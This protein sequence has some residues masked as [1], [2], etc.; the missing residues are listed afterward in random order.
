MAKRSNF[1]ESSMIVVR[2]PALSLL[3]DQPTDALFISD[4]NDDG[5]ISQNGGD[6]W[7]IDRRIRRPSKDSEQPHNW[8][9]MIK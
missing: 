2:V 9:A 5:S 7:A 4:W 8:M 1:I 6:P 3:G